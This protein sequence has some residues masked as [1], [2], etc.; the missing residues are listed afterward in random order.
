LASLPHRPQI[1]GAFFRP[2]ARM[3]SRLGFTQKFLLLALVLTLP[4]AVVVV[5]YDTGQRHAIR[6]AAHERVGVSALRPLLN[7]AEQLAAARHSVAENNTARSADDSLDAPI[8]DVDSSQRRYA[9]PL[10]TGTA[11]AD[12]R[13]QLEAATRA[14]DP[15]GRIAAYDTAMDSLLSLINRVGDAS[16]LTLD[17]ELDTYYLG[18]AVQFR[19]TVLLDASAKVVDHLAVA[20]R[21]SGTA[22]TQVLSAVGIALGTMRTESAALDQ[23]IATAASHTRDPKVSAPLLLRLGELD[24]AVSEL[25][26]RLS[27]VQLTQDP[28]HMGS[29]D[30]GPTVT[31]IRAFLDTSTSLLDDLLR[32]RMSRIN[33]HVRAIELLAGIALLLATYLFIAFYLSFSRPIRRMVDRLDA[34]AAGRLDEHVAVE[35]RDELGL[36]AV[37]INQMVDKVRDATE[38]LAHDA[39]HDH[40]TGLPNRAFIIN[41]LRRML[42]HATPARSQAVLFVDLDGFKLINDSLGHSAGDE[43]LRTVAARISATVRPGDM[44]AR[45]AGD[46]FLVICTGLPDVLPAADLAHRLLAVIV[47]EIIVMSA[48]REAH[49]ITVTASI[50]VAFVTQPAVN[51]EQ[52]VSD[53]DVAMYRAKERG[54]GRV[55]IFDDMLRSTVVERQRMDEGLR[56]ALS[57]DQLCVY[58]Q[59]V[60]GLATS[61]VV[62]YEALVRWAHPQRG[63]LEPDAF[64]KTAE[65]NGLVTPIGARVLRTAC[66]QLALWHSRSSGAGPPVHMAV[67]LSPRQLSEHHLVDHIAR[68][69]DE[70]GVDP[71]TV[72]LEITESA[73]LDD[74]LSTLDTVT[75]LS[76]IGVRIAIDDFG[77]GYSSLRHLRDY[78][79]DVVKIDQRFVAGL[80]HDRAD[81]A[82]VRSVVNLASSLELTLVAEGVE[83][84]RQR[85]S[86]LAVGCT[87]A[88]GYL[89]GR[90]APA[91]MA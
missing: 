19:L 12:M 17:P 40:L 75:A 68:T 53:A 22:Q 87:L 60:V 38:A 35:T 20:D 45:L 4:L 39:T 62:G 72:W 47:P 78:P 73:L 3:L 13:D 89:F 46:E 43:V 57:D 5:A 61:E 48:A 56:R 9:R 34:V 24:R 44:V 15:I 50:G 79:I 69:I 63:I 37:A 67:N 90:P 91:P 55:E 64:M 66:R 71:G 36:V 31:A 70:E 58:Y 30:A 51:A 59:P 33:G 29:Q 84:T 42:L 81:E 21:G 76:A 23:G 88:Q 65:V 54:R 32:A 74:S 86:L 85:E 2:A 1:A 82:I 11:W 7:L 83:T 10:N 28:S 41:H 49:A 27:L 80:G 18:D 8:A 52:L 16:E 77:T 14:A 25:T 6:T 26:A